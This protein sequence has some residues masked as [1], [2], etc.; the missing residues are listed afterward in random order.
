MIRNR[1]DAKEIIDDFDGSRECRVCGGDVVGYGPGLSHADPALDLPSSEPATV[2]HARIDDPATSYVAAASVGPLRPAQ[3]YVLRLLK[4][5]PE[6]MSDEQMVEAYQES[7]R[8]HPE[9]PS[10]TASGLRSRR[11]E[12]ADV[13]F[14]RETGEIRR[15]AANRPTRVWVASDTA[16]TLA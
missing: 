13:G 1:H 15:T 10:Q 16:L 14:V 2:A 6:G 4:E 7:R 5:H 12:L 11:K 9:V 8:G 3:R